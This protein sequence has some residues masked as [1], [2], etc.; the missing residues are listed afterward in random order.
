[1][2]NVNNIWLFMF[3]FRKSFK[4]STIYTIR[5]RAIATFFFAPIF[6]SVLISFHQIFV[7]VKIYITNSI[8]SNHSSTL[9]IV[10]HLV[11]FCIFQQIKWLNQFYYENTTDI[12]TSF[13][14][15]VFIGIQK[16]NDVK[17]FNWQIAKWRFDI[18]CWWCISLKW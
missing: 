8:D 16:R 2:S 18:F 11:E 7:C 17:M 1:M 3:S 6:F 10:N 13:I 5:E 15:P 4:S 14:F 9:S 12:D